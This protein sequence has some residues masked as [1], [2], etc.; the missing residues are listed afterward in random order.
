MPKVICAVPECKY[1]N[2]KNE[3]T[4]KTIMLNSGNIMTVWEGRKDVW[5]CQQ[6]E[7]SEEVKRIADMFENMM[8]EKQHG[9]ADKNHAGR[10]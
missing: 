3:C 5:V 6:F 9:S 7:M 4:A 2:D 8:K 10:E 1:N